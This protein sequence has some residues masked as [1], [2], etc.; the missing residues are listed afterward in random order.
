MPPA[1]HSIRRLPPETASRIAAGEVIERPL[2]ALKELI[3]NALDAGATRIEVAVDGSLDRGF[4]VA[5]DGIGIAADELDAALERHATSKLDRLEDLDRLATLGFRG[6]AL[7]SIAAVSR[8]RITSRTAGETHAATI[9]VE[10]GVVVERGDAARAPGTTVEVRDL[11]FNTPARR[12]FLKSETGELRAALRLIETCALAFPHVAMRMTVD[13][14]ERLDCPAAADVRE[15]AGQ[16]WGPHHAGQRVLVE[17]D[18]GGIGIV[19]LLGLPEHARATR[20]GQQFIVNR[21]WIQSP[22]LG[23]ALRQAYGNLLP[24]GRFPAATAWITVPADRLDVNV[25][26]TKREVRFADESGVFAALA[27]SC[28]QRLAPLHPPFTVIPGGG[29]EPRW[30]DRVAEPSPDQTRLGFATVSAPPAAAGD[31]LV[32]AA[33]SPVGATPAEPELWQLHATYILAPVR[34]GLVIVDQ[35]AAHE[36]ILYEEA[37]ARFEGRQGTSQQLLFPALVDLSRDQFDLV[38]ELGPWLQQLGWDLAPLGPPTVVVRGVPGAM[39]AS[40]PAE[41]L[42][43]VLD[44]MAEDTARTADEDVSER[45]ARSYAC[46]AAVKAGDPLT[47]EEMRVLL[48][49]LFATSRPHGDPHGR[50]TFVRLE[51]DDLHRRFGRG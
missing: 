40:R 42:Q 17:A 38:L 43:D 44:G 7:P 30:A 41:L 14:R 39:S 24:A 50:P 45:L 16:I 4:R 35:H 9:A 2:S 11:F 1:L 51:L 33:A 48:D 26:P 10:G 5:D 29:T 15:R 31:A 21:R 13:G 8:L 47:Q 6:E 37:R 25:H 20:D 34:G 32:A 19:A 12:K 46:H 28:A 27:A 36:R 3:E 23:Q 22:L 18:S 49:R